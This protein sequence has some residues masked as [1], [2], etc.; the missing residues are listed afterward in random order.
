MHTVERYYVSE[1]EFHGVDQIKFRL[2]NREYVLT[3]D[4]WCH[5]F[6]FDNRTT[7]IRAT[8]F[9]FNP[10]PLSYFCRIKVADTLPHGNN[11]ECPAIRYLYYVIANTL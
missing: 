3:L 10:S 9:T 5:H 4:E 2:M 1:E 6:G 11:I 8:C 7:A